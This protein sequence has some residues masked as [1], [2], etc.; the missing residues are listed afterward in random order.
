MIK[1]LTKND[2]PQINMV[3]PSNEI[4]TFV[5]TFLMDLKLWKAYGLFQQDELVGILTTYFNTDD[6]EWYLVNY[7]VRQEE[8]IEQLFCEVCSFYEDKEI[9]RFFWLDDNRRK[10][11]EFIPLRYITFK[12]YSV[13]STM[14]PK[15]Y[16]HYYTLYDQQVSHIQTHVYMSALNNENRK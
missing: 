10:T 5:N 1:K 2:I 15:T 11:K 3:I 8:Y 12:E 9:Y 14:F 13:D 7:Y 6:T 16:K 4:E